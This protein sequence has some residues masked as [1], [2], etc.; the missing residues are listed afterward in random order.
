MSRLRLMASPEA[1][2]GSTCLDAS[3][4]R[5]DAVSDARQLWGEGSV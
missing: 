1:D 4:K 5:D 3:M 2:F